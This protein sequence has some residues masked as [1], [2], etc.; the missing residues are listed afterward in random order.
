MATAWVTEYESMA[1]ELGSGVVVPIPQEPAVA[2]QKITF[3][4]ATQ[5]AAF[6]S[7]TK[8]IRVWTSAAAHVAFGT[9]PTATVNSTPIGTELV[10]WFGVR[11]NDKVSIYDGVS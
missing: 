3:T 6:N 2:V 1:R 8:I 9:N 5:S 11:A 4:T 7:R 10:E